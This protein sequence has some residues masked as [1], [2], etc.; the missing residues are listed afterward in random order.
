INVGRGQSGWSFAAADLPVGVI[1]V[2]RRLVQCI[3]AC[4]RLVKSIAGGEIVADDLFAERAD[5]L[6]QVDTIDGI[7]KS[8]RPERDRATAGCVGR[9][10][11][12]DLAVPAS[13]VM[14]E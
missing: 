12:S 11:L 9:N 13:D 6:E 1:S 8:V 7:G 5:L 4:V 14:A 3:I 10:V 2:N